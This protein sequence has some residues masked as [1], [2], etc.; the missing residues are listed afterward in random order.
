MK[1][2]KRTLSVLLSFILIL[3]VFTALPVSAAQEQEQEPITYIDENGVTKSITNYTVV[4]SD[5]FRLS[6]RCVVTE[7]VS[8]A[9]RIEI[10]GFV[11]LI[12][13]DGATL[14]VPQGIHL[15]PKR[16]LTVYGQEEGTGTL[17]VTPKNRY[18]AGIG[19]NQNEGCG[20]V[21]INGGKVTVNSS[22]H[23]L[24]KSTG[25]GAGYKG[26]GG[27]ITINGGTVTAYGGKDA[28]AIGGFLG[29]KG[30][31]TIN[32]GEVYATGGASGAGI[33]GSAEDKPEKI[34]ING[35][36]IHA[37][38]GKLGAGI[39]GGYK[40]NNAS[41][42]ING[43]EIHAT[44]G[45]GAA[46]IGNGYKGKSARVLIEG[47]KITAI[48]GNKACSLGK[49]AAEDAS[50]LSLG[51]TS[52]EDY[53]DAATF[54]AK[55]ITIESP[56]HYT[57]DG[58][59]MGAVTAENITEK[60]E[61]YILTPAKSQVGIAIDEGDRSLAYDS[62]PFTLTGTVEKRDKNATWTWTSSDPDVAEVTGYGASAMVTPK[63]VGTATVTA[64]YDSVTREGSDSVTVAV[65]KA[66]QKVLPQVV[67]SVEKTESDFSVDLSDVIPDDIGAID[68]YVINGEVST[69]GSVTVSDPAVSDGIVTAQFSGGAKGDTITIPVKINAANYDCT[70]DVKVNLV[71]TPVSHTVTV[72]DCSGGTV[73]ADRLSGFEGE[74]VLLNI[75]PDYGSY[76]DSLT[77]TDADGHELNVTDGRFIMPDSNVTVTASFTTRFTYD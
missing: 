36:V 60:A 34:R 69:G 45:T 15:K 12:L 47:G 38:G 74:I 22:K 64:A 1:T 24:T 7:D 40:S 51:W 9:R 76:F 32:G 25:I 53:I 71:Y 27:T 58:N 4:T 2:F 63:G 73:T 18:C 13:C 6:G 39:G 35:G 5:T 55:K 11:N 28:S 19:G 20:E 10:A 46:G 29:Q 23:K 67:R 3:G 68:S 48:G 16:K 17:I 30:L 72:A 56:F 52:S 75:N 37:T 62:K 66:P 26:A 14:K 41:V 42:Q 31:V 8:I 50:S 49:D 21:T 57:Q 43:G 77:V 61:E 44:G 59:D 54:G 70:V 33:G 65:T